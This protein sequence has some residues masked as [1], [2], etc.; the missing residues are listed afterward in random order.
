[1]IIFSTNSDPEADITVPT[2]T[3]KG[4]EEIHILCQTTL[5]TYTRSMGSVNLAY[6]K[7]EY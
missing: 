6:Q 4:E 7:R 3:G 1:M 2:K 5:M